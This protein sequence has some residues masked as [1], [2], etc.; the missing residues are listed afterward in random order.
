MAASQTPLPVLRPLLPTADKV[1]P[2]WRAIDESRWYSNYGPLVQRLEA[3]LSGHFGLAPDQVV[4]SANATLA[5]AQSLMALEAPRGGLCLMPSWTFTATPAAAVLAGLTPHFVDVSPK[6]W[7][8]RPSDIAERVRDGGV[9]AVIPVSPFGAPLDYQAWEAFRKETGVAVVHDVAAGFD[10]LSLA[11]APDTTAPVVIS[12]HA[13]KPFG[14]GEGALVLSRD[15]DL[16][17][18]IR[19]YGNFGFKGSRETQVAGMNAKMNEYCAAVGLALLEEWPER[20]AV[21]SDLTDA[22]AARARDAGLGLAPGFGA[23]WISS[24]GMVDFGSAKAAEAAERR[25]A[26]A[27]VETRR[28]WARACHRQAA[29]ADLPRDALPMTEA[30]A[31]RTLGLPFWPGLTEADLDRVFEA[32]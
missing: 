14:V 28:W 25:L 9:S 30:I 20:R 4:T 27:G 12:L 18:A 26:E 21:W 11:G 23:G 32:L 8:F 22:F 19:S 6:D 5:L 17:R 7:T 10:G 24:F 3:G 2:Y 1:L 13:T 16:Q 31:D 15:A 29:W